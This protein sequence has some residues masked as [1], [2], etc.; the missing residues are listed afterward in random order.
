MPKFPW[1]A[2]PDRLTRPPGINRGTT[3]VAPSLSSWLPSV[4]PEWG[5]PTLADQRHD[6]KYVLTRLVPVYIVHSSGAHALDARESA[7]AKTRKLPK[8]M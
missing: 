6:R 1:W 8:E 2:N 4:V 7:L 5:P 3:L